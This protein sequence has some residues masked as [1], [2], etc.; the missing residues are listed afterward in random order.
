MAM[1][2][3]QKTQLHDFLTKVE[4]EWSPF[5]MHIQEVLGS[6]IGLD[7]L[8]Q[9]EWIKMADLECLVAIMAEMKVCHE[10]MRAKV[11]ANQ[12][13]KAMWENMGSSEEEMKADMKSPI[14]SLASW[15]DVNQ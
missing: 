8:N 11:D 13:V 12:E 15:I 3:G 9:L 7:S 10:W 2:W 1:Y 6:S 4:E 14:G 5:L